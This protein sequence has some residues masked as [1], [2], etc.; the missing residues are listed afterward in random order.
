MYGFDSFDEKPRSHRAF[1]FLAFAENSAQDDREI[2]PLQRRL[3][4]SFEDGFSPLDEFSYS[5]RGGHQPLAAVGF[6]VTLDLVK[7]VAI[8]HHHPRGLGHSPLGGIREPVDALDACA[9]GE[10]E[11]RHSIP[12][13]RSFARV[14]EVVSA[15]TGEYGLKLGREFFIGVPA[16]R[17]HDFKQG[18]SS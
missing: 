10:M 4:P 7:A 13:P 9:V 16:W 18:L 14:D 3:E 1:E 6:V 2:S 12:R 15:K 11:M 17:I 8:V 5:G